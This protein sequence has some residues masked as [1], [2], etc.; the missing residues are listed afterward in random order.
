M[1]QSSSGRVGKNGRVKP[2]PFMWTI[3]EH[4]IVPHYD[5]Q[6]WKRSDPPPMEHE[7]RIVDIAEKRKA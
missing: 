7:T 6:F 1:Y 2:Q 5:F 4:G 3:T